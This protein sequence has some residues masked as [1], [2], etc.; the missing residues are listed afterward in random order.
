MNETW[1]EKRVCERVELS[2]DVYQ[3]ITLS[4]SCSHACRYE[5]ECGEEFGKQR[6][7]NFGELQ[8][9]RTY[10]SDKND[11][12]NIKHIGR[13]YLLLADG[14]ITG[15]RSI[16]SRWNTANYLIFISIT[17][18]HFASLFDVFFSFFFRLNRSIFFPSRRIVLY[19]LHARILSLGKICISIN[20][21]NPT[22][23]GVVHFSRSC[24]TC[25]IIINELIIPAHS[26]TAITVFAPIPRAWTLQVRP[27][28]WPHPAVP[29]HPA[30]SRRTLI[31]TLL[32]PVTVQTH[33]LRLPAG[34]LFSNIPALRHRP[35]IRRI[36]AVLYEAALR[37]TG[38][39][40]EEVKN[41]Y[42]FWVR[43]RYTHKLYN[44]F[45]I[46]TTRFARPR[47]QKYS[48]LFSPV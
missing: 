8:I 25:L 11:K 31:A 15:T 44:L 19:T 22:K 35:P 36:T 48:N 14:A 38:K 27:I 46:L 20:L 41:V 5:T 18:L 47:F 30:A 28:R 9:L 29:V 13:R 17:R 24:N 23:C 3:K 45:Q 12:R 16:L 40:G 2:F 42:I 1:P 4:L 34:H 6:D 33:H 43:K 26:V 21:Y 37:H 10:S 32:P 39:H 7:N